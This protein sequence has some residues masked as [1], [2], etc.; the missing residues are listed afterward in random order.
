MELEQDGH[1][2][3][4]LEV[5]Q[6]VEDLRLD[7]D[8]ER[9]GRLVGDDQAR[10]AGDGAGDEDALGHAAGQLV[11]VTGERPLGVGD[12]DPGKQVHRPRPGLVP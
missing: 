7:G 4:L 10:L 3:S 9:G 1:A 5:A 11:R 2:E 12:A 6:Q 8:V